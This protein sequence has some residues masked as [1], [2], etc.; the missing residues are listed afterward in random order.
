MNSVTQ[1]TISSQVSVIRSMLAEEDAFIRNDHFAGSGGSVIVQR[2]TALIDRTLKD[3][4]HLH[5][6]LQDRPSLVAIGGYGRGELNP[7]SDIDIMLLCRDE[8][9]RERSSPLLYSFWDAGLDI[10]YSVRTTG[11]CVDLARTDAKIRTSLLESRLIAGDGELYRSFQELMHAEVF[12]RKVDEYIAEKIAERTAS[13]QKFGGSLY[14]REPNIKESSG[15]LR[16]LHLARWIA[17]TRY[18]VSSFEDLV[19]Q[20]AITASE[21]ALYH[22]SRNFLWRVRNEVHYCSGRKNDQLT[23]DLQELAARDFR[24]RD[25]EDLLAVERFMK[26][27][28]LHARTVQE[29]SRM[30]TDRS[31]PK[32]K[33]GWFERPRPLG[34]F[35]VMGRTLLPAPEREY[36]GS[37]EQLM[38]ALETSHARGLVLSEGL[39]QQVRSCRLSDADRGSQALAKTFLAILDRL[40]GLSVTL[41][42]MRDLRMLGR[43]LPEFREIQGLA[44]H[45]YFHLFT[46]D[47]HVLTALRNLEELWMG[48]QS[49]LT[50]LAEAIRKIEKRWVLTLAVL[51][52]DLGKAFRADHEQR[53]TVIAKR[54]L[55]RMGISGDDR[56]RVLFLVEHHLLMSTLSQRREL[57]DRNVIAEFVRTVVDRENL[58][59][60]YLLTYADMTAV[61]PAVWTPWK[62]TLLQELFLRTLEYFDRPEGPADEETRLSVV[63]ARFVENASSRFAP[64][65]IKDFLATM[66]RHYLLT[67]AP[68]RMLEH[69]SWVQRLPSEQLVIR[70]EHLADRGC[71]ELSVCAYDAYGMFYRT[72]G[73]ISAQGLNIVRAKVYTGRNGIMIDTFEV[74]GSDGSLIVHPEVWETVSAELQEAL[75]A[76]RRPPEGRISAYA[77]PRPGHVPI[78]IS[79]DNSTSASL[80]IIDIV[81]RDQVG[82][83]YR[84]TKTLY[85]LN[86]DIASAKITTEGIQAADS[87]YVSD[88]FGSKITDP[89]RLHKIRAALQHALEAAV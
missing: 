72:A 78:D 48:R 13:R 69:L 62:A 11:E 65:M 42:L 49:A 58:S 75:T 71:T 76:G 46:V 82:L 50:S 52:H 23:Y 15:G 18:R 16:D 35:N 24:Y 83:L 12:N 84:I 45:D 28:F 73:T 87:F 7:H 22:R 67:T 89:D 66:P 85:D 44:R 27:Y 34:P 19:P 3:I 63:S 37:A 74:T 43:Y 59:L 86:L 20:G 25:S 26:T 55:E 41:T 77:R 61:G 47:E 64:E 29:F 4:Y 6:P 10:G 53:G 1:Q 60:L 17:M 68:A 21:L 32:L 40:E 8:R 14:L 31:L 30:V 57:G 39:R 56:R 81:A 51:L 79:F 2:R 5:G 36:M 80:T 33:R 54:V 70:Y 88:L 38:E 9:Q